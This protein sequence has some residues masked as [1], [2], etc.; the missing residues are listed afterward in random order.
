MRS[1]ILTFTINILISSL[2]SCQRAVLSTQKITP[3]LKQ[4]ILDLHNSKRQSIAYGQVIG[5]PPAGDMLEIK[6]DEELAVR[7]Q[8]WASSCTSE[9]HDPQRK[10]MRF[11]V[12]QN[13][14]T[15]WT[16]QK[17]ET[18]RDLQPDFDKVINGWFSEV[19]SYKYGQ[20]FSNPRNG[21]YTQMIWG[22]TYLIG[23]GYALYFNPSQGYTKNYVCNYGPG[24]NILL[25]TPYEVSYPSC[26]NYK[27]NFSKTWKGL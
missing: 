6:W 2:E 20:I 4:R 7:A 18:L 17:P 21:H 9:D 27:L 1:L 24:G 12:G 14:A 23:C 10:T 15:Y 5:Q 22:K 16:S 19:R 3:E 8:R 11:L 13:I 25:R 26:H